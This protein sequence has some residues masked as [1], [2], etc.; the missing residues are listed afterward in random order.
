PRLMPGDPASAIFAR[1]RGQ[2]QPEQIQAMREAYGLVEAPLHIQYYQYV[3][4]MLQGNLGISI[5]NFPAPVT[6]VMATGLLWTLLLGITALLVSFILGNILGILSAWRRGT[7]VDTMLPPILIFV[8]SFPF[9]WLALVAL[10]F[11]G[12]EL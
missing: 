1:M 7:L 12:F 4:N 2:L 5:S 8:G 9:F 10:Y 3:T 6:S 11:L